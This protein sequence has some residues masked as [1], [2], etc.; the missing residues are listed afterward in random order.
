MQAFRTIARTIAHPLIAEVRRQLWSGSRDRR[1]GG[2]EV[3][4]AWKPKAE[5]LVGVHPNSDTQKL[6]ESSTLC[7]HKQKE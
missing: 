2:A 3:A 1:S 4:E 7:V 5:G 6:P